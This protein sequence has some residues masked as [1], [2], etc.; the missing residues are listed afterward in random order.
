MPLT[1]LGTAFAKD[2]ECLNRKIDVRAVCHGADVGE[3]IHHLHDCLFEHHP[4]PP[5]AE[6]LIG[7]ANL[8]AFFEKVHGRDLEGV[9]RIDVLEHPLEPQDGFGPSAL[10]PELLETVI[11]MLFADLAGTLFARNFAAVRTY[12][13]E[14]LPGF[15]LK[16]DME[17]V[18]QRQEP[19]ESC[20]QI[21]G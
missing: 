8:D 13:R 21:V 7:V 18:G 15:I 3:D 10:G 14:A 1:A 19:E 17:P 5:A 11:R 16:I 6:V 9:V 20:G 12:P 4:D 2:F